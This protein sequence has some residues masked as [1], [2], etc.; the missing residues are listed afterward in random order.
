MAIRYYLI[1]L[2]STPGNRQS[3][4]TQIRNII[5]DGGG[6]RV[7]PH[8]LFNYRTSLDGRYLLGDA[9]VSAEEDASL[10]ALGFVTYIGDVEAARAYLAANLAMWER[11]IGG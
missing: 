3:R 9:E 11:P 6:G 4:L 5:T 2:G 8:Q 7:L 10:G 1:D